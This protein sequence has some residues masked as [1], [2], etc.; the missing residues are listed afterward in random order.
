MRSTIRSVDS[1]WRSASTQHLE[2]LRGRGAGLSAGRTEYRADPRARPGEDGHSAARR[3]SRRTRSVS[4]VIHGRLYQRA[5]RCGPRRRHRAPPGMGRGCVSPH[6]LGRGWS[7]LVR[8]EYPF[9]GTY[10]IRAETLRAIFMDL[11]T[12]FGDQGFRWVFIIHAHGSPS[13]NRALDEAGDYFRDTYGGRMIHLYGLE[14]DSSP[15]DSV[16]A[17]GVSKEAVAANGFEAHAGLVEHSWIMTLRPDLVP[18]GV[19]QAP[20]LTGNDLAELIRI[21]CSPDWPGYFGAPRYA[22]PE[23]G[24]RLVE[25]E[26]ALN[27][28]FVLRILDGLVDERQIPRRADR[29]NASGGRTGRGGRGKARRRS[30]AAAARMARE[31]GQ[32][33]ATE[34]G[35]IGSGAE[36]DLR[37]FVRTYATFRPVSRSAQSPLW[38]AVLP[39][40]PCPAAIEGAIRLLEQPRPI[41]GR[42]DILETGE[43]GSGKSLL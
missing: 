12:E 21:A 20:S 34:S 31:A 23:L 37:P 36:A 41:R 1:S 42:G 16:V 27:V 3:D 19:A 10:A 24:R 28:A 43:Q 30:R 6:P 22:T 17:S 8:G 35:F 7:K 39:S 38:I 13:H 26:T 40:D 4:S 32:A 18:P 9:P 33:V 25:A 29:G 11:A 5:H 14:R 15:S 2:S